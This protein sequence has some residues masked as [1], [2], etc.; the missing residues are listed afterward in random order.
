MTSTEL[1]NLKEKIE[2]KRS[3]ATK[4]MSKAVTDNN[5]A[6][7]S[8]LRERVLQCNAQLRLIKFI[9]SDFTDKDYIIC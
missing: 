3:Q 8:S 1:T 9:E 4:D 5:V 2:D 6:L 7:Q